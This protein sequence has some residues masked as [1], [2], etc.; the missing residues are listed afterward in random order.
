MTPEQMLAELQAKTVK[1][2]GL[3][4]AADHGS[5]DVVW[6]CCGGS[7]VVP[8]YPGLFRE[9]EFL[10]IAHFTCNRC[11]NS[12]RIPLALEDATEGVLLA[13]PRFYKLIHNRV[14]WTVASI[15]FGQGYFDGSGETDKIALIR[16]LYAADTGGK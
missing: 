3:L 15:S 12:D 9:C 8:K 16:A 2:P 4:N 7:G 14:G 10:H 1:C 6:L 5:P 11:N 13:I